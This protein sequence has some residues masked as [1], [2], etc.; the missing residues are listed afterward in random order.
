[1]ARKIER[2]KAKR[3]KRMLLDPKG[4]FVIIV[5]HERAEI[6]VEHYENVEKPGVKRTATGKLTKV[7]VGDDA[8][9]LCQT[10]VREG[11]VSDLDHAAYLGREL[12]RAELDLQVGY[13]YVQDE[14]S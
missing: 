12:K 4:F 9:A 8:E 2:L 6:V 3:N 13:R 10:I 1:M 7:I 11:L 5:D 14:D